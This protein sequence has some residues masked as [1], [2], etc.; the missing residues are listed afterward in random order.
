[1]KE[2]FNEITQSKDFILWILVFL[3][4]GSRALLDQKEPKWWRTIAEGVFIASFTVLCGKVLPLLSL[5][6]SIDKNLDESFAYGVGAFASVVGARWMQT[7][8]KKKAEK[9]LEVEHD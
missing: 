9:Y 8:I 7:K 6:F 4:G 1:M 2:W 5:F 3:A